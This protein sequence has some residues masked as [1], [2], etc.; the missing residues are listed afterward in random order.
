MPVIDIA[1]SEGVK[2]PAGY[3]AGCWNKPRHMPPQ[4]ECDDAIMQPEKVIRTTTMVPHAMSVLCRQMGMKVNGK[5]QDLPECEG[6]KPIWRDW[7]YI[8]ANRE[9]CDVSK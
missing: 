3:R 9:L 4:R 1:P 6:C 2:R 7:T 8:D 5:W